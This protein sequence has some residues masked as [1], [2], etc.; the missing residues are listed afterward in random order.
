VNRFV[1]PRARSLRAGPLCFAGIVALAFAV[2]AAPADTPTAPPPTSP[3]PGS[4][5]ADAALVDLVRSVQENVARL[6]AENPGAVHEVAVEYLRLFDAFPDRDQGKLA[7]IEV[8]LLFANAKKSYEALGQIARML[9]TYTPD[10]TFP[11]L[12]DATRPLTLVVSLR[13]ARARL[14][15]EV[16]D[17]LGA[18]E[19]LKGIPDRELRGTAGIV[20]GERTYY[21]P[22]PIL[23]RVALADALIAAGETRQAAVQ[24]GALL[25]ESAAATTYREKCESALDRDLLDRIARIA[26]T[27]VWDLPRSLLEFDRLAPLLRTDAAKATLLTMRAD[28]R[29]AAFRFARGTPDALAARDLMARIAETYPEI[30]DTVAEGDGLRVT[31]L[32]DRMLDALAD[33]YLREMNDIGGWKL[34]LDDLL[35]RFEAAPI[36]AARCH[37]LAGDLRA[38]LLADPAGARTHY[39]KILERYGDL[40]YTPHVL[41]DVPRYRV[42][43]RARLDALGRIKE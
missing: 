30:T 42:V 37:L 13:V 38:T 10:E 15:S 27:E 34:Y 19:T 7:G 17:L 11:N 21:G 1:R 41:P 36:L 20:D 2:A 5:A 35:R 29:L 39:E 9:R 14:L 31:R 8:V 22:S 40:V 33:L 3:P 16:G 23:V 25:R 26:R 32:A 28:A 6:R 12:A 24:I 43:V 4:S 18:V